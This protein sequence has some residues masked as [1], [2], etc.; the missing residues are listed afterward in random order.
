M[1]SSAFSAHAE[2]T[3]MAHDELGQIYGQGWTITLDTVI[4]DPNFTIKDLT[5]RSLVIGAY[6]ISAIVSALE[7][8]RPTLVGTARV[9]VERGVNTG[10]ELV[11]GALAAA[12]STTPAGVI[13]PFLPGISIEYVE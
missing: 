8:D 7:T 13:A 10:S 5:E 4:L 3:P 6:D 9:I 12:L 2:M 11:L 1:A